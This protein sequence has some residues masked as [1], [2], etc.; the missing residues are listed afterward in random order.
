ME[1]DSS[2]LYM[3]P[4]L[5]KL[6]NKP[7]DKDGISFG[8]YAGRFEDFAIKG[9]N[10]P[11]G[12]LKIP[13]FLTN[14]RVNSLM[15]L[16]FQSEQIIGEITFFVSS[17]FVAMET[18]YWNK[19][20]KKR[21]SYRQLLPFGFIHLPKRLGYNIT[22]CRTR[23]RY[24][25]ILSRLTKG[26]MH[27]DIDF[28]GSARR[29]ALEARFDI[30]FKD[31]DITEVSTVTPFKVNKRFEV[32]YNF[33]GAISGWLSENYFSDFVFEKDT[34][35]CVFDYRKAYCGL[36]TKRI[37]LSGFGRIDGK[38]TS[39]QLNSS[40]A[41]DS[42]T[43]NDNILI[44]GNEITTLPPVKITMPF[45]LDKKWNIQD[46]EGMIDLSFQPISVMS[47]RTSL[48]FL[49]MNYDTIYGNFTGTILRKNGKSIKLEN[50]TGLAKKIN[51]RF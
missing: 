11:F 12:N 43:Y 38:I 49:R 50:Y 8:T 48:F 3:R 19:K 47:R 29:P 6:P 4:I 5:Q 28:I 10:R 30:D 1:K 21:N 34:S 26:S 18:V 45:G 2:N 32:S 22:A 23:K 37:F 17:F 15:R 25:R 40:I 51:L 7:F 39:F 42:Y 16:L 36:K 20:T 31:S 35:T 13:T 9:L 33:N 41:P 44:Y 14:T 27:A 24:V 46:I